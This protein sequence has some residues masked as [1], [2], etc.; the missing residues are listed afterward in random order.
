[1]IPARTVI[2]CTPRLL[3]CVLAFS[4]AGCASHRGLRTAPDSQN[5]VQRP[6]YPA[7]GSRP[8]YIGGYA[9]AD[10]R[11]AGAAGR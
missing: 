9:G 2:R 8:F 6:V 3:L 10:Y 5:V 7:P 4:L 11:P 1:M